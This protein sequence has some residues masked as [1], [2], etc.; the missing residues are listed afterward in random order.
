MYRSFHKMFDMLISTN[1]TK[2][3][4]NHIWLIY[5]L[6]RYFNFP[7]VLWALR[8]VVSKNKRQT[9]QIHRFS[10]LIVDYKLVSKTFYEWTWFV[11]REMVCLQ[12]FSTD[13]FDFPISITLIV[14][15][16]N[17]L[18][19][20]PVFREAA[21]SIILV[22]QPELRICAHLNCRMQCVNRFSKYTTHVILI[23]TYL[24]HK[25]THGTQIA[26]NIR[27]TA[28]KSQLSQGPI[29][30]SNIR[31]IAENRSYPEVRFL[32]ATYGTQQKIVVIPMSD[33]C[34]QHTAH[35]RKS[36]LSKSPISM[37]LSYRASQVLSLWQKTQQTQV[38]SHRQRLCWACIRRYGIKF[39]PMGETSHEECLLS[40]SL[41][42]LILS[43]CALAGT[44]NTGMP[45]ECHW[46]TQCTLG[47]HWATQW[48]LAGYTGT[49]LEKLSSNS[50][51][52]E[53]HWR[54]L[55]E[56][57]S[58]WYATGE[59]LAFA[60]YTGTPLEGL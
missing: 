10:T 8:T 40:M 56:A 26:S 54:N 50:P 29:S 46:L 47:Y 39:D 33:L 24:Y 3:G 38:F 19:V 20:N 1:T 9:K 27:H 25:A 53:C 12:M 52:L 13:F 16:K 22:R 36:P 59:T 23:T 14:F 37:H 21:H 32:W 15:W 49:P 48:I 7:N 17:E 43:Q 44:V 2:R 11:D 4:W 60:A 58:R 18:L 55:V 35:S 28:E 45:L 31:H 30:V 57:A 42:T 5:P 6:F 34:K 51:T 41:L